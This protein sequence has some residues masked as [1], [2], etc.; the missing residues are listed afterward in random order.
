MAADDSL[1]SP[2]AQ[3]AALEN[4]NK[5]SLTKDEKRQFYFVFVL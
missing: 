5:V 2:H 3:P 1:H 4:S